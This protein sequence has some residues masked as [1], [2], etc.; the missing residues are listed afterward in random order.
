MVLVEQV[1][2]APP[3]RDGRDITSAD[4]LDFS[5]PA[6]ERDLVVI[7]EVLAGKDQ[8]GVVIE[9]GVDAV[10]RGVIE[11]G[12][13]DSVDDGAERGVDGFDRKGHGAASV[14]LSGWSAMSIERVL[15]TSVEQ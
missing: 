3:V 2:V 12:Q 6:T 13:R 11:V 9:G 5:E 8:Q 10:P 1:A 7:V 4:V 15:S 14:V